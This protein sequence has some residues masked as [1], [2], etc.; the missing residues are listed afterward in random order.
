MPF[1]GTQV[2]M[3]MY[4]YIINNINLKKKEKRDRKK[5]KK[6]RKLYIMKTC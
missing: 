3:Q 6:G 5:R 2:Y 4:T 1:S